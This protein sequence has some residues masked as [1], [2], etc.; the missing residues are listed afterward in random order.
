MESAPPVDPMG[1][2][3]LDFAAQE[4]QG[5]W[6]AEC[7]RMAANTDT[8]GLVVAVRPRRVVV[9]VGAR[10][11]GCDL[12]RGLLQG[13][14]LERNRLV[15]GDRVR[16]EA[17]GGNQ[18][19]LRE[20]LPR[21]SKISRVDS[22]R[23]PRE[24]VI[25]ANAEQL[26]ALQAVGE[27]PLN[28]RALDRFLVM[29]TAGGVSCAV[30]LNKIDLGLTAAHEGMLAT[31]RQAGYDV[32]ATCGLTGQGLD[33]V[34]RHLAGRRTIIVGPSGV[35]KS[36]LLNRL[37]PGLSL[38]TAE[39]STATGRGV[40]TTTRVEYIDLPAGGA[41][42]DTPGLRSVQPWV[43]SDELAWHF[44]E[45]RPLLGGCRFRDCLHRSEPDCAILAAVAGGHVDPGRHE[46][47]LRILAGLSEDE[48][49]QPLDPG[50]EGE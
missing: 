3:F 33:A 49:A 28:R 42:L 44:P 4:R 34:A 47:Y 20:I 7:L 17:T 39:I 41:V 14:R 50:S 11:L 12:R 6:A 40:H 1:A 38:R 26:L 19:V 31:Y 36:T 5:R 9:R 24:H 18:A 8:L 43:R 45:M 32:F 29:G 27:P 30:C 46:S 23:P 22:V 25:A 35:G 13:S 2:R 21:E 37:I 48:S 10:E 16:V 15:V